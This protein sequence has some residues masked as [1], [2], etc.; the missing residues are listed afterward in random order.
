M[1]EQELYKAYAEAA[2]DPEFVVDTAELQSDYIP[3]AQFHTL[4]APKYAGCWKHDN[5]SFSMRNKPR[6][7]TRIMMRWVFETTWKDNETTHNDEFDA[8]KGFDL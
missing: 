7:L 2:N 6:W 5:Y 8:Y 1:K 4:T 3:A